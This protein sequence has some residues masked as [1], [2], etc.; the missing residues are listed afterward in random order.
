VL[1]ENV[2]EKIRSINIL[3]EN[4]NFF[5]STLAIVAPFSIA[6][7]FSPESFPNNRIYSLFILLFY[8]LI[9]HLIYK[10]YFNAQINIKAKIRKNVA[11][12]VIEKT[13]DFNIIYDE[14]VKAEKNPYFPDVLIKIYIQRMAKFLKQIEN[15]KK[16][17][18]V[19]NSYG[20]QLHSKMDVEQYKKFDY[21]LIFTG[22]T[23]LSTKYFINFKEINSLYIE[24]LDSNTFVL[25]FALIIV[26]YTLYEYIKYLK[27]R[28]Y[29][30]ILFLLTPL[31]KHFL[32]ASNEKAISKNKEEL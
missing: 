24:L 27:L 32:L 12:K 16:G 25:F 2:I 6:Y 10:L 28:V 29:A 11:P 15:T 23:L 22:S 13:D 21:I 18:S 20:K 19:L 30:K 7:I 8:T 9:F 26:I 31:A 5:Y 4:N 14:L 1:G 3:I 17:L